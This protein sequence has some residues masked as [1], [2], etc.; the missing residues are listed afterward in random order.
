MKK[1]IAAV[2]AAGLDCSFM[3]GGA[4]LN[5][6]YREFVGADYYAKDAMESV[7]IAQEFFAQHMKE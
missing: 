5:E 4:V 7:T 1:T 6:D 2:K 3:V